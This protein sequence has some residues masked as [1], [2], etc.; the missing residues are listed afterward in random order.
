MTDELMLY[1]VSFCRMMMGLVF[2]ISAIGKILDFKSFESAVNNFQILPHRFN[3]IAASTFII[4]ESTV[5]F[6]MIIGGDW[7][8]MGFLLAG[9]LLIVF[10]LA[11]CTVLIRKIITTCNCFGSSEKTVS[12][13][14]LWRNAGFI[15]CACIGAGA[16]STTHITTST[17]NIAEWALVGMMAGVF[18]L[19]WLSMRD[20]L[21]LVS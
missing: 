13:Y 1:I 15:A 18:I 20:V 9:V 6:L 10:S 7:L 14:D 11:L 5:V 8:L 19:I 3:R 21:E 17:L 2:L 16:H 12:Y 4:G